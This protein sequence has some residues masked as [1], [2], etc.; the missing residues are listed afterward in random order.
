MN[1][2]EIL[3]AELM[4]YRY[5]K[6]M[7][8]SIIITFLYGILCVIPFREIF[9]KYSMMDTGVSEINKIF[10]YNACFTLDYSSI[11]M[12]IL[13][14]LIIHYFT[15]EFTKKTIKN[16]VGLGLNRTSIFLAKYLAFFI[17]IFL[18]FVLWGTFSTLLFSAVNGWGIRFSYIQIVNIVL[19]ILKMASVQLAY[20]TVPIILSFVIYN[21]AVIVSILYGSSIVGALIIS[22]LNRMNSSLSTAISFVFPDKYMLQFIHAISDS[23]ILLGGCI[24]IAFNILVTIGI[25][26]IIF[27]KI[28]IYI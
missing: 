12:F 15:S 18:L 7:K 19:S 23:K 16:I 2:Q 28:N 26:L 24:S 6:C 5:N 1:F 8:I 27:R 21:S 11:F 25:S 3:K 9:Q 20:A 10:G 13:P 4:K 17:T 22:V 14:F